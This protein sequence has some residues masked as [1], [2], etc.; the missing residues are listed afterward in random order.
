M[1][2][3]GQHGDP[4]K[5]PF[6]SAAFL[7]SS[8]ADTGFALLSD[9]DDPEKMA[10]R[11][12]SLCGGGHPPLYGFYASFHSAPLHEKQLCGRYLERDGGHAGL[13]Q[14]GTKLE[15]SLHGESHG[16]YAALSLHGS[17][18][19]SDFSLFPLLKLRDTGGKSDL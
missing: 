4:F 5:L 3:R 18:G 1:D 6:A 10:R 11:G 8:W 16:E 2:L 9:P 15:R 13:L 17:G 7:G 14:A 19:G 12:T